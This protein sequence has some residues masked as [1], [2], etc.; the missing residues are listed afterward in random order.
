M[1]DLAFLQWWRRPP[2]H[3]VAD[4]TGL[5]DLFPP[6]RRASVKR[7]VARLTASVDLRQSRPAVL[8]ADGISLLFCLCW[9]DR[10]LYIGR[11]RQEWIRAAYE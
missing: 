11:R 10:Q 7:H 5:K 3:P 1:M 2:A 6:G 9:H 4:R 8:D